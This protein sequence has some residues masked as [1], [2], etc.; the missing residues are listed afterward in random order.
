MKQVYAARAVAALL[1]L[2]ESAVAAVN[3]P[4]HRML[5][6]ATLLALEAFPIVGPSPCR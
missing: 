3:A 5:L 4:A 6:G 2:R 1:C